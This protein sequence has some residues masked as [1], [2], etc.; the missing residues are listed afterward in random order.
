M[1]V[2]GPVVLHGLDEGKKDLTWQKW[3]YKVGLKGE[4]DNLDSPDSIPS[5]DWTEGSLA[6]QKQRPLTWYKVSKMH[7]CECTCIYIYKFL[8]KQE[9]MNSSF[10]HFSMPPVETIP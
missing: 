3:S 1:G 10:R 7:T 2:Q 4:A 8:D 5:I 9:T 6:T